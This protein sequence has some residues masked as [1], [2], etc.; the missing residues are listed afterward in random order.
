MERRAQ[1]RYPMELA[2]ELYSTG[3]H[4]N[5]LYRGHTRDVSSNGFYVAGVPHLLQEGSRVQVMVWLPAGDGRRQAGLRGLGRV[6]RVEREDNDQVGMAVRFDRVE[7]A[8]A[9]LSESAPT[10]IRTVG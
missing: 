10:E 3:G 6:I 7:L 8:P 5:L 1:H 4:A 9:G 2:V